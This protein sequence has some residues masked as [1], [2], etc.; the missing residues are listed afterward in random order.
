MGASRSVLSILLDPASP[1]KLTART[2]AVLASVAILATAALAQDP[3]PQ[4]AGPTD[5]GF[6]L[7]NGWTITPA[8]RQVALPPSPLRAC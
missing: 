5:N 8:G 7:P 1:E 2:I 3:K 6:L 4:F